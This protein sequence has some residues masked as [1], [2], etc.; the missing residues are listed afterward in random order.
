MF[1]PRFFYQAPEGEDTSTGG[2]SDT[3][4][5]EGGVAY[6]TDGAMDIE[7]TSDLLAS[8]LG[9][10][11]SPKGGSANSATESEETD[12]DKREG[13]T[14]TD[15][16]AEKKAADEAAAKA[17]A[18]AAEAAKAAEPPADLPKSWKKEMGQ[19][20]ATLPQEVKTYVQER[21]QQMLEGIGQ[22]KQAAGFAH[23]VGKAIEPFM[24]NIQAAA[25]GNPVLA[26]QTLLAADNILRHGAP[27]KKAE[28]LA[29]MARDY[30][31]DLNAAVQASQGQAA[32]KDPY[33]AHLETQLQRLEQRLNGTEQ[34]ITADQAARVEQ[35]RGQVASEVDAFAADPAHP[36]FDELSDDIA[37]LINVGYTLKDAYDRAV[38]ANPVTRAKETAR[39]QK[40]AEERTRKQAEEEAEKAR[41]ASGTNVRGSSSGRTPTAP[42]GTM[43]DTMAETLAA[44]KSRS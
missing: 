26:V 24:A 1:K 30:G 20:W 27:D 37:K 19:H 17:A 2:G 32:A 13:Q 15:P 38:W 44:I 3:A 40:D 29:N 9:L 36:Y 11:E 18:E 23:A 43:E 22:Y 41:K 12:P 8:D 42:R 35:V 21:E 7:A 34:H 10:G 4:S 16:D 25:Q 33:V 5:I 39:V 6:G 28:L 14:H 31:V